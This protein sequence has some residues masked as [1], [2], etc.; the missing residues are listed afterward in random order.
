MGPEVLPYISMLLSAG[1]FSGNDSSDLI[2]F[3]S[4]SVNLMHKFKTDFMPVLQS[5]LVPLL[6]RVLFFLNHQKIEGTDDA[7][8]LI[9]LRKS[10]LSFLSA[11]F[12][13]EVHLVLVAPGMKNDTYLMRRKSSYF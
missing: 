6:E 8:H 10:Y 3:I 5:M 2:D 9:E 12:N 7:L 13:S 1:L 4:L 11:I